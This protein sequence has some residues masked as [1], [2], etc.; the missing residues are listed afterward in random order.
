[1]QDRL[2]VGQGRCELVGALAQGRAQH[3]HG[4]GRLRLR[5]PGAE[6]GLRIAEIARVAVAPALFDVAL[7]ERGRQV[8]VVRIGGEGR[9]QALQRA[10]ARIEAAGQAFEHLGAAGGNIRRRA[11]GKHGAGAGE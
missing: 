2:E 7:G 4:G 11:G 3:Q 5:P 9:A 10:L 6:R 8:Q 1:L